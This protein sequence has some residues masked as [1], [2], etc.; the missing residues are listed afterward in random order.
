[1]FI[2]EKKVKNNKYAYLVSNKWCGKASRQKVIKYLG[3]IIIVDKKEQPKIDN[4]K[5]PKKRIWDLIIKETK[6]IDGLQIRKKPFLVRINNKNCVLKLNKGYLCS[7]TIKE[8][9]RSLDEPDSTRSG[10]VLAQAII[11]AGLRITSEDF[12]KLYTDLKK[13]LR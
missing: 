4:T 8:L 9:F 2:R 13:E 11:Q 10:L 1:M 6:G 7:Y 12:I 5:T 3:K